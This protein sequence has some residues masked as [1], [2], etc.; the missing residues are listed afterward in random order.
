MREAGLSTLW[1]VSLC[2]V[3]KHRSKMYSCFAVHC[4][5]LLCFTLEML[6]CCV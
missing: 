6:L 1:V 3:E 4:S 5:D 2:L